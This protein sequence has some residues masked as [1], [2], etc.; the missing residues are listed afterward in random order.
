MYGQV[1]V[2]HEDSAIRLPNLFTAARQVASEKRA[3]RL[4]YEFLPVDSYF[5][6]HFVGY[7]RRWSRKVLLGVMAEG[8][9]LLYSAGR[10]RERYQRLSSGQQRLFARR[11]LERPD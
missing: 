9:A 2:P 7:L 3:M 8:F 6:G 4:K 10:L 11:P 1:M 5:Y